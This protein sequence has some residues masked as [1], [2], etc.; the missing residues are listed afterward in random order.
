MQSQVF[1]LKVGFN[2]DCQMER[3]HPLESTAL[4]SE[5]QTD[6]RQSD[7]WIKMF[8]VYKWKFQLD[9]TTKGKFRGLIKTLRFTFWKA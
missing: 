9:G 7:H 1:T 2:V 8:L 6:H 3:G 5:F 4:L